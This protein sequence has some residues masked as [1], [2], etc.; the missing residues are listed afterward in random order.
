MTWRN[1]RH[2]I[3]LYLSLRK[4]ISLKIFHDSILIYLHLR[5]IQREDSVFLM[6]KLTRKGC[7]DVIGVCWRYFY[8]LSISLLFTLS[9]SRHQQFREEKKNWN[10]IFIFMEKC[11]GL[12]ISAM[13]IANWIFLVRLTISTL[14]FIWCH[15]IFDQTSKHNFAIV[16]SSK[17]AG[18]SLFSA[19]NNCRDE[20]K[21][22]LF[23]ASSTFVTF[24]LL[25]FVL[26]LK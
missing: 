22:L 12:K 7:E 25:L 14:H 4:W 1:F 16:I 15:S 17:L 18:F 3:F 9:R 6:E 26:L 20:K 2:V 8:I 24:F 13:Q 23:F 5:E 10:L 11:S 19:D 21:I